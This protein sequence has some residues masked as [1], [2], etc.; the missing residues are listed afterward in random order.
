L[1]ALRI[2]YD[3]GQLSMNK[4]SDKMYLCPI[5]VSGIIDRLE[6][7]LCGAKTGPDGPTDHSD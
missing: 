6:R 1:W 4:L 5:T 3:E 2:V 7:K